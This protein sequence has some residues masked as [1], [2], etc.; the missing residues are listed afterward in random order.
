MFEDLHPNL[1]EDLKLVLLPRKQHL[2]HLNADEKPELC[3]SA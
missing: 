3:C 2:N 1:P